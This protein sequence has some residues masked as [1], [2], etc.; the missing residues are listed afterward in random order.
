MT[1]RL[2][3]FPDNANLVIRMA[4]EELGVPYQEQ[5]VD[6]RRGEHRGPAY[7][8][9]NPR[10]LLPLL[11]DEARG[12]LIF[13]TAAILL[14]L[15]EQE[16]ALGRPAE[17][18]AE[19]ATFLKWLF[20]LSNTLH[21]DLRLRYYSARFVARKEAA[22]AVHDKAGERVQDHFGILDAAIAE[23]DGLYLLADGLSVC[24]FYIAGCL[25]WA[26]LYPVGRSID[27]AFL[28]RLPH[29]SRLLESLEERPS[30]RRAMAAEGVTAPFFRHPSPPDVSQ[31]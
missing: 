12:A 22:E 2:H 31:V 20:M 9:L 26:R 21:A 8:R 10:G 29:L 16:G 18:A 13:E 14:Y 11:E 17:R 23:H 3:Y 27:D 6:R 5:L 30:V 7:R 1:Y 24:D 4:L 25:R 15:T 19:R 28:D